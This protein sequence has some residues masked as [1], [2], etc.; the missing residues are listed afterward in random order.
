MT[1][2]TRYAHL[3]DAELLA[4]SERNLAEL[5][6]LADGKPEGHII[7]TLHANLAK[8]HADNVARARRA[9][10]QEAQVKRACRD[11][12]LDAYDR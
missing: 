10:G 6:A 1:T 8:M 12:E 2:T 11:A 3:T 9:A 7:H 4:E 5:A